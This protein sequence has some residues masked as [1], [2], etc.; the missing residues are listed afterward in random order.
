MYGSVD[1]LWKTST[2]ISRY[3]TL[4]WEIFESDIDKKL[5]IFKLSSWF[6]PLTYCSQGLPHVTECQ[7]CPSGHYPDVIFN[8][9]PC[10][11]HNSHINCMSSTATSSTFMKH[12]GSN[13]FSLLCC[14]QHL[15]PV[16]MPLPSFQKVSL[17]TGASPRPSR[18]QQSCH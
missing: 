2:L 3:I 4:H 10:I 16:P 15:P 13:P 5:N 9:S 12:P 11:L 18:Q 6:Q 8:L 7:L 17:L 14:H 1:S